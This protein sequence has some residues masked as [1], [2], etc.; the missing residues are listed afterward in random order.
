MSATVIRELD[1]ISRQ[2]RHTGDHR[3]LNNGSEFSSRA[4]PLY[5]DGAFAK[6]GDST[7]IKV[8]RA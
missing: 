1:A 4:T 2:A 5:E 3:F 7:F 6:L 8:I